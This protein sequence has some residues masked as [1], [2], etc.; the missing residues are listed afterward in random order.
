MA[1]KYAPFALALTL[2]TGCTMQS[3]DVSRHA[4]PENAGFSSAGPAMSTMVN[5]QNIDEIAAPDSDVYL[6]GRGDVLQIHAVDAPELTQLAGYRV[7]ADGTIR[8]PFLGSVRAAERDTTQIRADIERRLRQYLPQP[9]VDLRIIEH[10]ARHV[11]VIGNVNR[12]NRQS[13]TS[14]PLT[15]ID[16]INA[17]GGFA[18]RANMRGVSILRG[19]QEIP[20]DMEGFLSQGQALP[21]LRDGDVVQVARPLRG[22]VPETAQGVQ[23]HIPGQQPRVF[24]LGQRP[25]TLAQLLASAGADG[26]IAQVIRGS[27]NGQ[28]AYGFTPRNAADP[29]IG[30]RFWLQDGDRLVVQP[31]TTAAGPAFN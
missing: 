23:L 6:V 11:T 13:L 19:G 10:N 9:Q 31:V 21:V 22:A 14:N 7:E 27:G 8:V 20:V 24:D 25:V 15:V 17:A 28:T 2:A 30:G 18:P 16:A 12:P 26:Q 5:A 3:A 4:Q 1:W 29:A